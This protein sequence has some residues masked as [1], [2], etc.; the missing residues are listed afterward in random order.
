MAARPVGE[1]KDYEIQVKDQTYRVKLNGTEVC[2]F[3]N[4]MYP[5]RSAPSSNVAP[6]FIGLQVYPDPRSQVAY[7]HIRIQAI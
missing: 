5:G 2:V 4:T 1:W 3:D 6:S 7:R